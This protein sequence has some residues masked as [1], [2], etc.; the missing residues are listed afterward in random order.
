[1]STFIIGGVVIS[2]IALAA[3]LAIKNRKK[4]ACCGS[5]GGGCGCQPHRADSGGRGK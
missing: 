4:H 5:C 1:M 2:M 3:Y